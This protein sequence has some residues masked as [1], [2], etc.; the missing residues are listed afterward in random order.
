M[1]IKN[2]CK[3]LFLYMIISVALRIQFGYVFPNLNIA[4]DSGKI[5]QPFGSCQSDR[6]KEVYR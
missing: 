1:E 6:K 3:H 2:I 5:R 4:D